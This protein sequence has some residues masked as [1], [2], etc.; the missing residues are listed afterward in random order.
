MEKQKK[1][2]LA[3]IAAAAIILIGVVIVALTTS[4]GRSAEETL[5][6]YFRGKYEDAGG[7]VT[8]VSECMAPSVQADY[9]NELTAAGTNFV[10]MTAWR[11]EATSLVGQ[12]VTTSVEVLSVEP[13][14]A[15]ALGNIRN[16]HPEAEA[17]QTVYFRMTLSGKEA[18]H[19]FEGSTPMLRAGG[20]WYMLGT[21][22]TLEAIDAE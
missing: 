14:S 13:G 20:D 15:A 12:D 7:G 9:Y 11:N 22:T 18:T 2:K 16:Q 10:I 6:K 8:A 1:I 21:G 19:V 5:S 17:Y 3:A 4:T